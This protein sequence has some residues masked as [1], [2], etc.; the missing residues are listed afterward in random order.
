VQALL[1]IVA[2]MFDPRF[3]AQ[4]FAAHSTVIPATAYLAGLLVT[5]LTVGIIL[6][7][8]AP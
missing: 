4:A 1:L 6:G 5:A 7:K 2:G 3:T 8:L